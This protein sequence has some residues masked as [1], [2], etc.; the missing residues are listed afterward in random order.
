M[1]ESPGP[2]VVALIPTVYLAAAFSRAAEMRGCRDQLEQHGYKVVSRWID[3]D[4]KVV[5]DPAPA[6][7]IFL[8]INERPDHYTGNA[9]VD[10]RDLMHADIVVSFTGG[11]RRGGRHVEFGWALAKAKRLIVVG[12]REHVFHCLPEVE[13]HVHWRTALDSLA[14]EQTAP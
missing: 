2:G 10:I 1:T 5:G 9:S 8:D 11:G 7:V 14:E 13:H 6:D 3:L 12:P 4:P